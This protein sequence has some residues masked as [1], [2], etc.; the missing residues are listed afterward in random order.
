MEQ[1]LRGERGVDTAG[2]LGGHAGRTRHGAEQ[3]SDL[4]QGGMNV[5]AEL[6]LLQVAT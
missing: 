5:R 6:A 4:F 2:H 1:R 3:A